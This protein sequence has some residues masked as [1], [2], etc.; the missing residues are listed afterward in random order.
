MI[1]RFGAEHGASYGDDNGTIEYSG[2]ITKINKIDQ[3]T[4]AMLQRWG[5]T[6]IFMGCTIMADVNGIS[7]NQIQNMMT[8]M[9]Q[10]TYIYNTNNNDSNNHNSNTNNDSNGDNKN[11]N[12]NSNNNII[13][14]IMVLI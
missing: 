12:N 10:H 14:V 11:N 6:A 1:P 8:N 3:Q 2:Y 5:F 13:I 9:Y 4:I 7:L